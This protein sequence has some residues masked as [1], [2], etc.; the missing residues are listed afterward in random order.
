MVAAAGDPDRARRHDL[1]RRRRGARH[2]QALRRGRRRLEIDVRR[3]HVHVGGTTHPT[4]ATVITLDGATGEVIAGQAPT[5]EPE[6]QASRSGHLAG[7]GRRVAHAA[8]CAPTPTRP[9][10]AG[11]RARVRRRGHRPVPHRAHV[12]RGRPDPRHARDD[13]GRQ[14]GRARAP[15]WPSCC[16]FQQRRLRGHLRGDGR[17]PGHDPHAR[18]AA[19][20]IPAARATTKIAGVGARHIGR[21]RSKQS[22]RQGRSSC[23][24][25][26]RCWASAAAASASPTPRSPRCRRARS[27]TAARRVRRSEGIVVEPE[28]MIPLVGT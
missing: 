5:V 12:L 22:M 9:H 13:P 8:A 7:L 20:R 1:A 6:R 16:R 24:K 19:A 3:R 27:S 11:R 18:P 26:T 17:L 10:D 15:R 4:K 2:G 14:H 25:P 23:A 28:I 21:Y